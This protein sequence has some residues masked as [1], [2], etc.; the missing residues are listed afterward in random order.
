MST[1]KSLTPEI[2]LH[3][4]ADTQ[5]PSPRNHLGHRAPRRRRHRPLHRALSQGASRQSRR[6]PD[7]RHIEK[8]EY[9]RE[10]DVARE[11]ILASISEQGKLTDELKTAIE[12]TL[13]K[14][15]LEDLYLPYKPK[16]RTKATIAREKGLEPLAELSLGPEAAATPLADIRRALSAVKKAS[17]PAEEASK[18][19]ATSSPKRSAKPPSSARLLRQLMLDEGIVVSREGGRPGR[20]GNSRCI[21]TTGSLRKRFLRTACWPSAAAKTR[22]CCTS[23][24]NSTRNAPLTS[25]N[26]QDPRASRRLDPATRTRHRRRLEAPAQY[27]HSDR[28]AV[29]TQSSAPTLKPSSVPRKSAK[30]AARPAGRTARGPRHRPR[31]SHRLQDR[32]R[33]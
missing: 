11:T 6:S 16:R 31:H 33:R 14:N 17:P 21:P 29:R 28:S 5:S 7:P 27:L 8:L 30:P 18:E 3:V 4:R 2:L 25:S 1:P 10:L 20:A 15:E 12:K 19:L 32:G 26:S 13:D 22:T 9:F 23:R 24:S